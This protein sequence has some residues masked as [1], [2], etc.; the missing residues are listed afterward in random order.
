MAALALIAMAGPALGDMLSEQQIF[1]GLT[2]GG[3]PRN[4]SIEELSSMQKN[5]MDVRE[6]VTRHESL[7]KAGDAAS[8]E[9]RQK[10]LASVRQANLASVD[11]EVNFEYGSD[12][13]TTEAI[14]QLTLVGRALS[15]DE[16]KGKDFLVAGHTDA[17]GSDGFNLELSRRRA[18]AVREFLMSNFAIG[19]AQLVAEGFGEQDLKD[20]ANPDSGDNRRVEIVNLSAN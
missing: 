2:G 18:A 8:E 20:P 15:R 9:D 7:L 3:E 5:R 17:R 12:R 10:L 14:A 6:T 1:D 16:L 11:L 13:L 19:S 4:L